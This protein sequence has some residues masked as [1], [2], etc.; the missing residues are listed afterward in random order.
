MREIGFLSYNKDNVMKHLLAIEDHCRNLKPGYSSEHFSC[1]TKHA[2]QVEEQAE[3]G[4]SHASEIEPESVR[5]F[6]QVRRQIREFR[7]ELKRDQSPDNAIRNI[8]KIRKEAEKMD[9]EYNVSACKTCRSTEEMEM[10]LGDGKYLNTSSD[11]NLNMKETKLVGNALVGNLTGKGVSVATTYLI[12]GQTMG[13][14]NKTIANAVIGVALT[15]LALYEK[16]PKNANLLG[17]VAGT[18]LLANELVNTAMTYMM[19]APVAPIEPAPTTA[20][21]SAT[22]AGTYPYSPAY[23]TPG[24]SSAY[25][26]GSLIV[27]D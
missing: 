25:P 8:R 19:P 22:G 5:I 12:P 24:P 27:V 10:I 1:I 23:G 13:I 17:A 21:A 26:N 15:G 11:Q 9:P 18:N 7:K 2:L 3:E 4:I 6:S 16:L 14:P 20:V